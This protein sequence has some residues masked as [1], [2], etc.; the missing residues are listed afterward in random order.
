LVGL[1]TDI[2]QE[3][4]VPMRARATDRPGAA[5][6]AAPGVAAAKDAKPSRLPLV[7]IG[8]SA[9]G[10]ALWALA[11][12]RLHPDDHRAVSPPLISAPLSPAL[13]PALRPRDEGHRRRDR[14]VAEATPKAPKAPPTPKPASPTSAPTLA[15][16][17]AKPAKVLAGGTSSRA[18]SSSP[19]VTEPVKVGAVPAV[20]PPARRLRHVT[21]PAALIPRPRQ[22]QALP[23]SPSGSPELVW[24]LRWLAPALPKAKSEES[25]ALAALANTLG[26]A[27]GAGDQAAGTVQV[28]LRATR[29]QA[30]QNCLD[31][32]KEALPRSHQTYNLR[33][34]DTDCHAS[35]WHFAVSNANGRL[36]L[37]GARV[38]FKMLSFDR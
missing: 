9:L 29:P 36:V 24:S 5:G 7:V 8:F 18:A 14:H 31:L 2:Q 13:S 11:A 23:P 6:T 34:R 12:L 1:S 32:M 4:H 20:P 16:P 33:E 38:M 10:L 26:I 21:V 35:E 28:L 15:V 22:L 3:R 19:K 27:P 17:G 25:F 30:R 37:Q